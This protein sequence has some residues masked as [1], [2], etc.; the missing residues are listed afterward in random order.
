[1]YSP[2]IVSC[3]EGLQ[4]EVVLATGLFDPSESEETLIERHGHSGR[5]GQG[6]SERERQEEESLVVQGSPQRLPWQSV[7]LF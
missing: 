2:L 5:E 3:R 1:M 6:H 4:M 7:S